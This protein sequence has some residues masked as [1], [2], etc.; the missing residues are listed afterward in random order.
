MASI[1][2]L[3]ARADGAVV[4][5]VSLGTLVLTGTLT[6][7]PTVLYIF[8]VGASAFIAV[9][10]PALWWVFNFLVNVGIFI[11]L[12]FLSEYVPRPLHETFSWV[13]IAFFFYMAFEAYHTAQKKK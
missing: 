13:R 11:A 7:S 1:L 9:F 3:A 10:V 6:R 5:S 12:S 8:V 2:T 4:G